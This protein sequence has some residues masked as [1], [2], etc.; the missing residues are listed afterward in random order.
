MPDNETFQ[1]SP[2]KGT[3]TVGRNGRFNVSRLDVDIPPAPTGEERIR[4]GAVSKNPPR[5]GS[6]PWCIDLTR[7]DALKLGIALVHAAAGR[8]DSVDIQKTIEEQKL[9]LE[10]R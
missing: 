2:A 4:V 8:V 10:L 1:F 5:Y 3:R 6:P 9:L 7:E